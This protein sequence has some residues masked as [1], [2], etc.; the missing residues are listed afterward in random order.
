MIINGD[1]LKI[2][3]SMNKELL[4]INK[5]ASDKILIQGIKAHNQNAFSI[6]YNRYREDI[7]NHLKI[8]SSNNLYFKSFLE[9]IVTDAFISLWE[10]ILNGRYEDQGYTKS[11]LQKIA[12]FKLLKKVKS[13][14]IISLDYD[15][16]DEKNTEFIY[17][18]LQDDKMDYLGIAEKA[19]E[20]MDELCLQ[21]ILLKYYEQLNDQMIFERF[22]DELK[23]LNNVR[24]RRYKCL[25]KL[26]NHCNLS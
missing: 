22:P 11:Y 2:L 6:L 26:K 12:Y 1:I 23:N 10:N 4:I 25:T 24:K 8:K 20:K 17:S 14:K 21:I 3:V 15:I 7:L 13:K 16:S 19:L 9:E 18:I 5:K